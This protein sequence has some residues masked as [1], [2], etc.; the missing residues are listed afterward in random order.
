MLWFVLHLFWNKGLTTYTT[1]PPTLSP[2]Q[3]SFTTYHPTAFINTIP[4][5]TSPPTACLI[6]LNGMAGTF[7]DT[8]TMQQ[9]PSTRPSVSTVPTMRTITPMTTA[10]TTRM[11]SPT[12]PSTSTASCIKYKQWK[13]TVPN[14]HYIEM[15]L[16][17]I[18]LGPFACLYDKYVIIKDGNLTSSNVLRIQ[19]EPDAVPRN[20]SSSGTEMLVERYSNSYRLSANTGFKARYKAKLL[21]DGEAPSFQSLLENVTVLY[22]SYYGQASNLLCQAQGAPA[23]VITWYNKDNKV[24]QKPSTSVLYKM[25]RYPQKGEYVCEATNSF[26]SKRKRFLVKTESKLLVFFTVVSN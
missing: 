13:I 7:G 24:L 8:L 15:T 9:P 20:I 5:G 1:D 23:P 3:T 19:C 26:G 21:T 16:E 25:S 10:M 2:Y 6:S 14:G 22:G 18:N 4:Y 11:T 17:S 12:T